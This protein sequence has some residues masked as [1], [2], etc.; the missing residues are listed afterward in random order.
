MKI[1]VLISGG[2][3]SSVALYKTVQKYPNA[4]ITAYYLKIWLEDEL[5]YL[6]NCPWEEDLEFA[7]SVCEQFHVPLKV[8]SL[9]KD[10]HEKV[11]HYTTEQ[12]KKGR[13]PS[14]DVLCNRFIKF[15]AFFDKIED[16]LD[17]IVSGHYAT[18]KKEGSVKLFQGIDSVK[19]Q[20]YFLAQMTKSQLEMCEFP[21]GV[22]PKHE[23]RAIAEELK[24]SNMKRPDSQGICF[25]GNIKYNEFVKHHLGTKTGNIVNLKS[26]KI[27]GTHKG[28]WFH[29][30]GQRK[31]LG[32]GG[33]PWMVHSKDTINNIIYVNH[34]NSGFAG[35]HQFQLLEFNQIHHQELATG[36]YEIKLRHGPQKLP[37]TV[38]KN[39]ENDY[40]AITLQDHQWGVA[41][42]QFGVLYKENQCLGSGVIDK[43]L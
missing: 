19:D 28:F 7:N 22:H 16:S 31:G 37:C 26:K 21:L 41:P 2:V 42:G 27:L 33:G 38:V 18:I 36:E 11:V 20:S 25:L 35:Y 40:L 30:I 10:Y 8:V 5:S 15:G 34:V 3:D 29:T 23:V 4:D 12:L 6:G 14:P 9:Q 24:L 1:G 43:P 13:T 39:P 32:L 17:L